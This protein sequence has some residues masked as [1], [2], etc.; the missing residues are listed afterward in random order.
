MTAPE[1]A[2][3]QINAEKAQAYRDA[4]MQEVAKLFP[5]PED[6]NKFLTGALPDPLPTNV[7][8][9]T[10]DYLTPLDYAI[11]ETDP[12][13]LLEEL[14][15]KKVSAVQAA[16]AYIRAGVL[17]QRLLN[18]VTEFLPAMALERA[19][20]LDDYLAKNGKTIGPLHGLP[21]SLK[22]HIALKGH[23]NNYSL[24]ALV[25]NVTDHT[26]VIVDIVKNAGAVF[27][28]RTVQPQFLM[29]L[30]SSSNVYGVA[31]NPFNTTLTCGGSSGGEAAALG[32]HS[33]VIGL[34][35]DIGGSIR[36]PAS[37]QGVYGFKPSVNRL[38]SGDV[39]NAVT[40]SESILGTIGPMGR[41][42]AIVELVTKVILDARPWKARPELI[43]KPWAPEAVLAGK[44]TVRVGVLH[45]DG[46]VN[47][48]PPVARALKEVEA[49]LKAAGVVGDIELEIVPF[50]PYKHD[51]AWR[52]ISSLYF[53]DG[54]AASIAFL[55]KTGEPDM[56]LTKFIMTENENVRP[57]SLE[58]LWGLNR[59]KH[60]YRNAYNTH[61]AASGIDF[62]ISPAGP[63]AAQPHGTTRYWGY[64]S[65]WNLLDY[66][67]VVFPVTTV[68]A[69]KDLPFSAA[70]YTP[71][72][73]TDKDYFERYTPEVYADAPIALQIV[74]QHSEDE[75]VI[76]YLKLVEQVLAN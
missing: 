33:A 40:G 11:I 31:K 46:V 2:Q 41:T 9:L 35:T 48:Q 8:P 60:A 18:N 57:L 45:S 20:F 7:T 52:I 44:K 75:E 65:Q 50:T 49:K 56:E 37:M 66:P 6:G 69:E 15:S 62:L 36:G 1:K 51:E 3:W 39:Y 58:D 64:T 61:W 67:G 54:G 71:L 27:Y 59:E 26:C 4:S 30:E 5:S 43:A 24:T 22:D 38:P 32:F 23:R 68:D 13:V 55:R 53:E 29:H 14:A 25:D 17:G 74:A 10:K 34:G 21:F 72:N 73:A 63:G 47:P 16:G 12:L 70:D 19:Q 76:E 28:Q 42:L